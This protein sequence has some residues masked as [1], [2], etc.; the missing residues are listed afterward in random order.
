MNGVPPL[1]R[2]ISSVSSVTIEP[3]S[4]HSH[5]HPHF[6]SQLLPIL[7]ATAS[8]SSHTVKHVSDDALVNLLKGGC[9]CDTLRKWP[10]IQRSHGI[11]H[12]SRSFLSSKGGKAKHEKQ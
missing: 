2:L 12:L 4:Q 11:K 3:D 1:R 8:G 6:P 10:G 5:L 7:E 9:V